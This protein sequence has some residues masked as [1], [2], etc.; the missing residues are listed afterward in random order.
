MEEG[1]IFQWGG[2][3]FYPVLYCHNGFYMWPNILQNKGNQA[4]KFSQF[5]EYKKRNI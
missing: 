2:A 4:M 1:V 3:S 5:I